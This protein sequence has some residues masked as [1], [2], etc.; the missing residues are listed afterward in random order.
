MMTLLSRPVPTITTALA[1]ALTGLI[2]A[3]AAQAQTRAALVQ[4]VDEP[5]RNPYQEVQSNTTCRGTTVC[6]FNYA[7]VP[8]GKRL[9][10]TNIAGYVDTSGGGLPNCFLRSGLGGTGYASL[11]F[12]GVRGSV[13][14]LGQ[15]VLLTHSVTVY[16]GVG[17]PINIFCQSSSGETMSGG[18]QIMLSGHYVNVP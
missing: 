7:D 5:A 15:R 4:S 2:G 13:S 17:E 8:A 16:F 12:S 6:S 1:L 14:G 3:P 11:P 18:A 9:V 10:V